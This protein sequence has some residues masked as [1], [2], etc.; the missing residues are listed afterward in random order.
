MKDSRGSGG[1]CCPYFCFGLMLLGCPSVLVH[2]AQSADIRRPNVVFSLMTCCCGGAGRRQ[3]L[4]VVFLVVIVLMR[5]LIF[6]CSLLFACV[7]S[8]RDALHIN[9]RSYL[10]CF[11]IGV[12]RLRWNGFN[13]VFSGRII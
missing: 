12:L 1:A 6:W 8:I 7:G 5:W 2:D 4:V 13:Q 9:Q 10:L 11:A 3:V